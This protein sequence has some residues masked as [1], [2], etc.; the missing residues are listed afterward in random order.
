MIPPP[1]RESV[2]TAFFGKL[3]I[4]RPV[5]FITLS[6]KLKLW[7]ETPLEEQPALFMVEHLE[8]PHPST[9]GLPRRTEWEIELYIY[10][11]APDQN[12]FGSAILNNLLDT[13]EAALAPDAA[14][15][16]LTLNGLV[17]RIWSEGEIR[18][19]PGD[20]DGQAVAIFPWRIRPP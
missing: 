1:S 6:R 19:D 20:L 15:N 7:N 11:R 13:V 2:M 3:Q 4:L 18:K 5:P 12:V 16:V 8:R 9:R 14:E 10:A 17:Y